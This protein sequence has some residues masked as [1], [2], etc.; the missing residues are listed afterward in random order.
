MGTHTL[1]IQSF[2]F[3]KAKFPSLSSNPPRKQSHTSVY[4]NAAQIA[5]EGMMSLGTKVV[6]VQQILTLSLESQF[7]QCIRTLTKMK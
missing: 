2:G 4:E 1:Q 3:V 7:T 5:A 6:E